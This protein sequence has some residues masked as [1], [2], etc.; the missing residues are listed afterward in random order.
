MAS[1]REEIDTDEDLPPPSSTSTRQGKRK[2]EGEDGTDKHT[3]ELNKIV[4]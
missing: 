1:T 3:V 2:G 4:M